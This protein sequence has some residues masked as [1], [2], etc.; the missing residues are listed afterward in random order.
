M[1]LLF[2]VNGSSCNAQR[3]IISKTIPFLETLTHTHNYFVLNI[4]WN[5]EYILMNEVVPNLQC[6]STTLLVIPTYRT[7]GFNGVQTTYPYKNLVGTYVIWLLLQYPLHHIQIHF[8]FQIYHLRK[9]DETYK[10]DH[11]KKI[12]FYF[13]NESYSPASN[14]Y[15]FCSQLLNL[16]QQNNAETRTETYDFWCLVS[17]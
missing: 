15:R 12:L 14:D 16:P 9:L 8:S 13:V 1:N 10:G 7:Q 2:G 17:I 6:K 11:N 3:N 4:H 5:S